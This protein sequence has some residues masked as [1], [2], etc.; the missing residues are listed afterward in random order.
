LG[1]DCFVFKE[2]EAMRNERENSA[3]EAEARKLRDGWTTFDEYLRNT[4]ARWSTIERWLLGKW[5]TP[6]WVSG[7]DVRQDLYMGAW[8][9]V[10]DWDPG[11]LVAR[12]RASVRPLQKHIEYTAIDCAKKRIHKARKA[13]LHGNADSNPSRMEV[14]FS[15]LVDAVGDGA[16]SMRLLERSGELNDV[17]I[18][19]SCATVQEMMVMRAMRV[20]GDVSLAAGAFLMG[21][22]TVDLLGTCEPR[23]AERVVR[24]IAEEVVA[25]MME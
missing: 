19:E 10:W 5:A 12:R 4:A 8:K 25:R 15:S 23:E 16:E 3:L 7:G 2:A 1:L 17:A 24:E 6:A 13:N 9:G 11:H 22:S 18:F 21:G 20:F 14:P